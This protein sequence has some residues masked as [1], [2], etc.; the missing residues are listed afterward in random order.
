VPSKAR[1]HFVDLGAISAAK[2]ALYNEMRAAGMKKAELARR[3][4]WQ[5]SQVDR[6]LDLM[7]TSRLDQLERAL[8]LFDKVIVLDVKRRR[9]PQK[10]A[11]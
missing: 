6:L 2:V 5:K 7:H 9:D 11:S 1:G 4:G 3:L 8:A 10:A